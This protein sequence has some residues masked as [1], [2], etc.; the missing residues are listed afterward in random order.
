MFHWKRLLFSNI[1]INLM[2]IFNQL[3]VVV[4]T[5]ILTVTALA[6]KIGSKLSLCFVGDT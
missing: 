6:N 3:H 2:K 1:R 4:D 5:I